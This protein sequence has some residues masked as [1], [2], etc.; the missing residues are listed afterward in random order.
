MSDY[1][2]RRYF[3]YFLGWRF[4]NC[5]SAAR[6]VVPS[7]DIIALDRSSDMSLS[8]RRPVDVK[9]CKYIEIRGLCLTEVGRK[10]GA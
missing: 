3:E 6:Y 2:C 5:S 1:S 4:E 10:Y 7:V 9:T 8:S